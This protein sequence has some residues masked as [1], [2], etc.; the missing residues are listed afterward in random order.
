MTSFLPSTNPTTYERVTAVKAFALASPS[1]FGPKCNNKKLRLIKS[2]LPS[3]NPTTYERVT[4][5]KTFALAS[6][7]NFG[8]KCNNKKLR[9]IK[10]LKTYPHNLLSALIS[11][12][13]MLC[14]WLH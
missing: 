9:L 2:F 3:T 12:I 5:V 10:P 1:N 4:A 14:K 6:P 13:S 7:S 8:L 11:N